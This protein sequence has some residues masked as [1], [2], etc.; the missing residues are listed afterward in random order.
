MWSRD[1]SGGGNE[2]SESGCMGNRDADGCAVSQLRV[3]EL[4]GLWNQSWCNTVSKLVMKLD[5]IKLGA[6]LGHL[7]QR[8]NALFVIR[9]ESPRYN[10]VCVGGCFSMY[11]HGGPPDQRSPSNPRKLSPALL[12]P[13]DAPAGIAEAWRASSGLNRLGSSP[14]KWSS[15][16]LRSRTWKATQQPMASRCGSKRYKP[17]RSFG[18]LLCTSDRPGSSG[19]RGTAVYRFF[20]STTTGTPRSMSCWAVQTKFDHLVTESSRGVH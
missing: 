9:T 19:I 12:S 14:A 17:V 20:L 4:D 3:G 5:A 11:R 15:D 2:I 8:R 13:H 10:C 16:W 18:N 1:W 7:Y 6:D